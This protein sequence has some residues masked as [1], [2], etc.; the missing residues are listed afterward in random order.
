LATTIDS[1]WKINMLDMN[2]D[3]AKI[4][5]NV[6]AIQQQGPV[7]DANPYMEAEEDL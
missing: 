5:A 3:R 7:Q 1:K 4:P 2:V 6:R